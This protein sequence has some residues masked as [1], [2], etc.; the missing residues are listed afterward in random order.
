[1]TSFSARKQAER[2]PLLRTYLLAALMIVLYLL[3]WVVNPAVSLTPNGYELAEWTSLHPVVR[4][5]N[6]TLIT[7][8][9]LRLPLVC[10]PLMI[11]FSTR[12]GILPILCVLTVSAGLLPPSLVQATNDPNSSQQVGLVIATLVIGA[13]GFSG[14]LRDA[15]R[16]ITAAIALVGVVACV[17][18]LAQGIDLMQGFKL[19]AQVGLGGAALAV[20]FAIAAVA[21]AYDAATRK[22]TGQR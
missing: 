1:L 18:G 4:G 5:T 17:I 16:W 20:A 7:S 14:T 13:I 8:L 21:Y 12:R 3:P 22:Q 15:R 2:S 11:V 6:P 9:L 19:P 10:I